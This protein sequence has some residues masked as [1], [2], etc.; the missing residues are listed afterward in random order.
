[1]K[2][3]EKAF[4]KLAIV[5]SRSPWIVLGIA[6]AITVAAG[7]A[8]G[9]LRME[10]RILDLVPRDDPASI[11]FNDIVRQYSSASQIMVGIEGESRQQMIAFADALKEHA[12]KAVYTDKDGSKQPYVKRTIVRAD[13]EFI[14]Q[15]GLML[16]KVRDLE[17]LDELYQDLDLAPLLQAYNDFLEREYIEDTGAVTEREKE[18]Q[19]IDGIKN[20]VAWLEGIEQVDKGDKALETEADRITS[21]LATGTTYM[22]SEDDSMLLALV[23]PA[24]SLDQMD[25]TIE[26]AASL[27]DVIRELSGEIEGLEVRMAGMPMLMLDELGLHR[28][29]HRPAQPVHPELRDHPDRAGHRLLDPPGRGLHY[30]TQPWAG[31]DRG[32]QGDVPPGRSG[33]G[34]RRAD[35]VDGVPGAGPDRARRAGRAGHR[36]RS[37]YRADP[38]GLDHRPA[39]DAGDPHPHRRAHPWKEGAPAQAGAAGPA[40]PRFDG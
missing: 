27:R 2:T 11:E 16:T 9:T 39:G 26:G 4:D 35:Y 7:A 6:L 19:A 22:F 33:G 21:L 28:A 34:H 29:D 36:A 20:M 3:R 37:R 1:M 12:G 24:I 25:R 40:L 8:S 5:V 32:D 30:R 17:N 10:T 13:R 18:D 14:Q 38:A 23:T 31:R 15:H